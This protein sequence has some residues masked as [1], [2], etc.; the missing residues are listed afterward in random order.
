M[1]KR[2]EKQNKRGEIFMN[3]S[4]SG[5]G[6]KDVCGPWNP[7]TSLIMPWEIARITKIN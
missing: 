2:K 5:R 7:L 1:K 6:R 3:V 4:F